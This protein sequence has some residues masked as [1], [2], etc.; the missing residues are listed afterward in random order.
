M[1][2]ISSSNTKILRDSTAVKSYWPKSLLPLPLE[3]TAWCLVLL[4]I[5]KWAMNCFPPTAKEQIQSSKPVVAVQ[6]STSEYMT[7]YY[8]P[9]FKDPVVQLTGGLT[10]FR[11][12]D[13][14]LRD[15]GIIQCRQL[16]RWAG[17]TG[18]RL[19][20]LGCRRLGIGCLFFQ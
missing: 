6:L 2:T 13:H 14:D 12:L 10:H 16:D 17:W 7:Q 18:S 15:H 1:T 8:M 9:F 5:C 19:R 4:R 20:G 11:H 3:F